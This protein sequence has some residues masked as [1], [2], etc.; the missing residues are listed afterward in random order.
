[1]P[2]K[3]T[4]STDNWRPDW[5]G[6]ERCFQR[7]RELGERHVELTT[8]TGFNL[9]EGLGF[10]PY[11]SVDDDPFIIRDLLQ[12]YGLELVSIDCDYPIWSHHS[13]DVLIKS[14][15]FGDMIGCR[16]FVTTDSGN[17]PP[18]RSDEEWLR[19]IKYHFDC[20]LPVAERHNAVIAIEPHGY[21]TTKPDALWRL[22]TQ[23]ASDRIGINFDT[24]NSFIAGQDPVAFLGKVKDRVVHMHI[25]DVSE[26]LARAMGGEETG[27]ASSEIAVGEGVNAENIMLC[28]DIM[29][30]TGREI[31]ISPEAGGD[32]LMPRSIAWVRDYLNRK[33]YALV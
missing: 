33:G 10:S 3:M 30:A 4:M 11:I 9:L 23:N 15:V 27:I 29:A 18:G 20:V 32:R 19:V 22:A 5:W 1:M 16:L 12:K 13:I 21:L 24:G 28:L 6:V 14:I 8:A 2:F 25:K 31:P 26:A 7:I 17:Y